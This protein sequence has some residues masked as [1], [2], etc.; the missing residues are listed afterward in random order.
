MVYEKTLAD[1]FIHNA[2]HVQR[3]L[4]W[5]HSHKTTVHK[6]LH[7]TVNKQQQLHAH[8]DYTTLYKYTRR[9]TNTLYSY[10]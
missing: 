8:L 2:L 10:F 7:S 4:H 1:C 6:L 5:V 9:L 3:R